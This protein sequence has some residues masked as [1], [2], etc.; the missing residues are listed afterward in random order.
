M[1]EMRAN[2]YEK[3]EGVITATCKPGHSKILCS[4]VSKSLEVAAPLK[5]VKYSFKNELPAAVS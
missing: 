4:L 5:I 1:L 3:H 2:A